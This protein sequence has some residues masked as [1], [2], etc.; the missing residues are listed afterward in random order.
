MELQPTVEEKINIQLGDI[1]KIIA[2]TDII[3][4]EHIYFVKYVDKTRLQLVE[5]TG[6]ETS[7]SYDENGKLDNESIEGIEILSRAESPSYA[8]QNKLI[9]NIWIDIYFGGDIPVVFTGK[10]TNLE[11]DMIEIKTHPE[12]DTIFIDFG[13]KGIP[14]E[15]PIEKIIIREA[16]SGVVGEVPS[17]ETE[18]AV[19]TSAEDALGA[20][21]DALGTKEDQDAIGTEQNQDA[22]G[23]IPVDFRAQ[24]RDLIFTADQIKI[25]TDLQ[26]ITQEVDVPE[27]EQRFSIDKQT[28]D[29]LDELLSTVPNIQRTESVLNGIHKM[30]ERFKQLRQEFSKFDDQ[31]NALMPAIQGA[32]Y[33]PLVETLQ[34]L[35]QKLYWILP[36]VKN[37]RKL[38]D[39]N[40]T[41]NQDDIDF[42][43][44]A[45]S[46]IEEDAII[47]SYMNNSI[48]ND[49]NKYSYLINKLNPYLTPYSQPSVIDSND[50]IVNTRVNTSIAAIVDNLTNNL[51][52]FYSSVASGGNKEEPSDVKQRRFVIQ[53]Y[54][55]GM[56]TIEANKVKGGNVIIKRKQITENDR[57]ALSSMLML[58]E[59]TVRFSRVNMPST[60]ILIKSNLNKKFLNYWQVLK[61][62]TF[63]STTVVDN[64]DKPI[65]YDAEKFLGDIK[66]FI[67]DET[68]I[69]EDKFKKYLEAIVP[70]TRILFDLVKPYI[71]GKLSI[72]T[73]LSYLEPFMIYQ[74]D[75]SFKQYE[76]INDFIIEKMNEFKKSYISSS[77]DFSLLNNNNYSNYRG[78]GGDYGYAYIPNLVKLFETK[79]ELREKVLSAYG[80]DT[81]LIK[82]SD[83]EMLKR[84]NDVDMGSLYN[85]AVAFM[86]VTLMGSGDVVNDVLLLKTQYD[87][88]K[89]AIK[90]SV[91]D[92]KN[93]CTKYKVIA[94]Y[95]IEYDEL[96]EDNDTEVY[97]DK[98]YDTTYYDILKEYKFEQSVPTNERIAILAKK[99]VDKNGMREKDAYREAQAMINGKRLVE[100]GDYAIYETKSPDGDVNFSYFIRV[101]N[102]WIEDDTLPQNL[103]TDSSKM[104]CN[105]NEKCIKVKSDCLPTEVG[106]TAIKNNTIKQMLNEVEQ[107][108]TYLN[109]T[110]EANLRNTH[111]K[112]KT[113]F[114]NSE[115][116][117]RKIVNTK[118]IQLLKYDVEKFKLGATVED[119]MTVQSPYLNIRD[120]ILG[121]GD[122]VKRQ[123]DIIKFANFFTREA[124]MSRVFDDGAGDG[125]I[126][127]DPYWYY[128]TKTNTK[129]LPTFLLKI[130][131]AFIRSEDVVRVTEL[132]CADQGTISEDGNK[133]V[134]K[135]S[136]YTIRNIDLNTE[137]EYTEEGFKSIT[138]SVIE[139]DVGASLFQED[140]AQKKFANPEATKVAN[141]ISTMARNMTINIEAQKEFIIRNV[142][143]LQGNGSVMPSKEVFMKAV[144][145]AAAKGKK[146][147]DSYET[148]YNA[149]LVIL[150]LCY[151]LIAV[152]ISVP[153]IKPRK[154]FPGCILP[155]RMFEQ[156]FPLK[157]AEDLTAITYIACV[158]EKSKSKIEPWNGIQGMKTPDIA[159]RMNAVLVRFIM[160]TEEVK[161]GIK[162]KQE[163][164]LLSKREGS[165]Q[166]DDAITI[167]KWLTF[168][169]PLQS[170]KL[171]ASAL[172]NVTEGFQKEFLDTLRKGSPKQHEMLN[173]LR[174]KIITFS[175][176]IIEAIQ[177]T[178]HKKVEKGPI[179]TN[180]SIEPF[181]ENACCD[182]GD[183]NTLKYFTTAEPDII[184]FNNNVVKI[185]NI[186]DDITQAQKG[187]MFY[188][189][190][191]TKFKFPAISDEF[192]EEVIYKAFIVFCNYTNA[193]PISE[194]LKAVCMNK[195]D[196]QIDVNQPLSES[197]QKLKKDGKNYS[198]ESFNQLLQIVNTNNIVKL[199]LHK[200]A[201]NTVNMLRD[202]LKSMEIR[203]V[204]N[205]PKLFITNFLDILTNFEVGA[206][207]E[208]TAEMR[209]FKN[210]LATTN[211]IMLTD[212]KELIK[213]SP[214][215]KEDDIK[216]FNDCIEHISDFEESG[217]GIFIEREETIYKMIGFIKRSLR[218]MTR[219]FPTIIINKVDYSDVTIPKHWK[220]SDRHTNDIS[221]DISNHYSLLEQY[222]EDNDIQLVM[223][224]MKGL[225]RD[226]ELLSTKTV[227]FSPLQVAKDKYMYS[228]FD[229]RLT[230]M[231]F[232]FY[233][234]SVMTDIISLKDDEEI[235]LRKVLKPTQ[236]EA[237]DEDEDEEDENDLLSVGAT[238][239]TRQNVMEMEIIQ[240]NKKDIIEK[241]TSV[242]VSFTTIL[243]SDKNVI[244]YNYKS[245]MNRILQAKEKETESFTSKF[246]ALIENPDLKELENTFKKL[247][248]GE[249]SK[250]LDKSIF[251]YDKDTYDDERD[252]MD[253]QALNELELTKK[254]VA[255]NRD[256][257]M[258]ELAQDELDA[259]IIEGEENRI[260]Y[261][262]EDA[263]YEDYGM[264]GDE[265]FY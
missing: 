34:K 48:P 189:P 20:D 221:T 53:Q 68:I 61:R 199:N 94:K 243:C 31:G 184:S 99:L 171:S 80:I 69:S 168:L 111:D 22:I 91:E 200:E 139:A 56:T 84:I 112:I 264:D 173:V 211:T 27:S 33:K 135:Y 107:D 182:D 166:G 196:Y 215:M 236:S 125:N 158:A 203:D 43:T 214:V 231:L 71:N 235:L 121:Q 265:E 192:S 222:Y 58:P 42:V 249:W 52:H 134:D 67:L 128:C 17:I 155:N 104:F 126:T 216:K 50:I 146:N 127:E 170:I 90:E 36:V 253:K 252:A 41:S 120:R 195:P 49:E 190:A 226:I 187:G 86:I 254:G 140:K 102:K 14:Q 32:D 97:F 228:V 251:A 186:I 65:D 260:T 77:R 255:G 9:P 133:W 163:Y 206:L 138:R 38:Y 232:K 205:V 259:D 6:N 263:E 156:G 208:D 209:K 167:K 244:D 180:S 106:A 46:R 159:K 24:L 115:F 60:N 89:V 70:K 234:Y 44:L 116:R 45:N 213:K 59:V 63:I 64:L 250:G 98:K 223:K 5:G 28:N 21:Q 143:M 3:L 110:L 29:L 258:I 141:I 8:I 51:K 83:G 225:S 108:E 233:L 169:P 35:N 12:E 137:E 2:P 129:L 202:V 147:L 149:S 157:D 11:E 96:Q 74:K 87:K 142:L 76:T 15:L 144:A 118:I 191:D 247:K 257:T 113:E 82:L 154:T 73:I 23:S 153:P 81:S 175:M 30:I 176:G 248:L 230:V 219:E 62:N 193:V 261:M 7:I 72:Y 124:T 26:E 239:E 103:M 100:D 217:D 188:D 207:F 262:G 130:A 122:Y 78:Q 148:A 75:L 237:V 194:E 40:D 119:N 218:S 201:V 55:L 151:L 245:L 150:T 16:P 185:A 177:K 241:I 114:D 132:I 162:T 88:N 37:R 10:I 85:N 229:R 210:Y 212:I 105:L 256:I 238:Y 93:P 181:L 145:A 13:Y 183:I 179:L 131:E 101:N 95:Y 164:L 224:K 92:P 197:I 198:I 66:Q 79:Q 123:S 47:K 165:L 161:E 160:S 220:L 136:G 204:T 4:N 152:Q 39:I 178:I 109:N 54:N 18:K 19:L 246:K 227:F 174:S 172:Q 57:L 240:G 117:I 1:I 242:L 25:G